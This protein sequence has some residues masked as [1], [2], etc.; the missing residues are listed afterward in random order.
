MPP[1]PAP[2]LTNW[3]DKL[4]LTLPIPSAAVIDPVQYS[5]CHRDGAHVT[6]K[7][8]WPHSIFCK[9]GGDGLIEQMIERLVLEEPL[10]K[11][12]QGRP[13]VFNRRTPAQ[14]DLASCQEGS[15][16]AWFDQIRMLDAESYPHAFLEVHGMRLEFRRVCQRTDGLHADVRITAISTP[17]SNE[18]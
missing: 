11:P 1:I 3:P 7:F 4:A 17:L 8:H 5:A 2:G 12:Q 18:G 16:S 10:A 13:V 9:S 6:A 15:L 14:S